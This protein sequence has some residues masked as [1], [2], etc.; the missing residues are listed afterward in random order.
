M[1]LYRDVPD[2]EEYEQGMRALADALASW[3][4]LNYAVPV[5]E[6]QVARDNAKERRRLGI[7]PPEPEGGG[8]V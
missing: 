4:L 8:D 2:D 1:S 6:E 3:P 5:T 7:D